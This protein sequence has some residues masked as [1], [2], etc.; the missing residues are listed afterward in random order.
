MFSANETRPWGWDRDILEIFELN[1]HQTRAGELSKKLV[2]RSD[3]IIVLVLRRRRR[4]GSIGGLHKT[5]ASVYTFRT[6]KH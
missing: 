5:E 4:Q 2:L 6:L 3:D 1:E